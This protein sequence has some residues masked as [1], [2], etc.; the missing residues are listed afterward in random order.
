M[1][2]MHNERVGIFGASGYAGVELTR[3]VAH[4]GQ[5]QLAFVASE[6]HVG[7]PVAKLS[8]VTGFG[9]STY[10]DFS[11]ALSAARKCS[12]VFLATP[13]DIS[14]K[15]IS[16]LSASGVRIV[17]LSG[18]LRLQDREAYRTFYGHEPAPV[19]LLQGAVYGLPELFR[20]QIRHAA[21]IANP[22]CYPTAATLPLFPLLKQKLIRSEDLV[23]NALSG[24]S[25]AGRKASEDFSLVELH[26]NVKPY[27][28][29]THQH[30]PEIEQS[31]SRATGSK[32]SVTFTPHLLPIPRG[33]LCTSYARLEK[34]VAPTDLVGALQS[35]YRGEAFVKVLPRAEDVS[36]HG[37]IGTNECHLGV[38]VEPRA[39]GRV[40]L[41]SAIDNLVKGAA[42]QALQ[43]LNLML[44]LE[45]GQGL[46]TLRRFH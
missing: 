39:N 31:L 10:V 34:G 14:L 28:V 25:G 32:V 8:G 23:I 30:T 21:L 17:D 13:A 24:A 4:H 12:A 9:P 33:I 5:L 1:R 26:D 45:Q 38:A 16:E 19:L 46:V 43:N 40:V 35:A 11:A 18:A 15:I 2:E 36:L 3:L 44:G 42:G 20:D 37:V 7:T 6:R 22:G 27:K 41:V 29:L